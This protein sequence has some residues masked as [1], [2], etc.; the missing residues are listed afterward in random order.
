MNLKKE[1]TNSRRINLKKISYNPFD[2]DNFR[3]N[4]SI[5]KIF[6]EF[7]SLTKKEIEKIKEK[8]VSVAGRIVDIRK[9]GKKLIFANLVDNSGKIQ[10]KTNDKNFSFYNT[11]DITGIEGYI[12]RTNRGEL[13]IE[14][15]KHT[16]LSKCLAHFPDSYYGIEDKRIII[17]KR[18]LDFILKPEK[19]EIFSIRSKAIFF[20]RKLLNNWGFIEIETPIIVSSASG[21]QATPFKTFHEKL[22]SEFFLRIAPELLLKEAIISGQTKIYEI[23]KVFRNEGIDKTHNP[24]FTIIEIYEAYVNSSKMMRICERII[25]A[26]NKKIFKKEFIE[27]NGFK[28]DIRKKFLK[29]SMLEIIE[30]NF[31]IDFSIVKEPSDAIKLANFF[32]INIEKCDNTIGHI[33]YAFFNSIEKNIIQ[34]TFI[35]DFP[36]ETSPLAKT[37]KRNK[38]FAQRFEL[39]GFGG[40]ELANGYAELND[41]EEQRDRFLKQREQRMLGRKEVSEFDKRFLEALEYGMPPTGG[42]GMGIDRIMM[43]FFEQENIKDVIYFP[44]TKNVD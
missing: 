44:Q 18:F 39:F 6:K 34:P 32:D 9:L 20:L 30:K 4:S 10:L 29:I 16:L 7:S 38:A 21:A 27:F 11:G 40:I 24:E 13:T 42:L 28:V 22:K 5:Y 15:T 8:K 19:R 31:G 36:I 35:F 25:K 37:K 1:I 3:V 23:G 43:L 2:I 33:I 14:I 12:S 17:K 41:S 26:L